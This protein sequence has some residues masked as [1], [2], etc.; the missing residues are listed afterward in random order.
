MLNSLI[1]SEKCEVRRLKRKSGVSMSNSGATEEERFKAYVNNLQCSHKLVRGDVSYF[2]TSDSEF[3][4]KLLKKWSQHKGD[5]IAVKVLAALQ[6]SIQSLCE[7]AILLDRIEFLKER[8]YQ[9]YIRTVTNDGISP[10][11]HALIARKFSSVNE[12]TFE[13]VKGQLLD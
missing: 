8:G 1:F 10:R 5:C 12:M 2:F 13:T 4:G 3:K 11:C 6:A 9:S 7:N